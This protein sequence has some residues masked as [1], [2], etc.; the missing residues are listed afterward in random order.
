MEHDKNLFTF[1]TLIA[2][3]DA[4]EFMESALPFRRMMMQYRCAML[5]VQT[6]F[7]VLNTELSLD[8]NRNPIESIT[9]RLK[10]PISIVEKL[11]RKGQEV[12][13]GSIRENI[14]DVAGVRV[15]CSFPQDIYRLAEKI[16]AQDDIRLIKRKDY[17][18]NPKPNGYRS[19]HLILEVPVFFAQEKKW[20]PVEV[21]LRTI[22]MDFWAS[23][24]HKLQYKNDLPANDAARISQGLRECAEEIHKLDLRM[25]ALNRE[26]ELGRTQAQACD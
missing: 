20:M 17:I 9:C 21:Q 5:E 6:K 4:E 7:N 3:G 8:E 10:R 23:I 26:M 22:A 12:S 16:C 25:Q 11:R 24:E 1:E 19:L 18:Q 15:I 13:V 14:Y 2:S